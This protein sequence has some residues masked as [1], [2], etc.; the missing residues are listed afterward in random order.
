MVVWVVGTFWCL[1]VVGQDVDRLADLSRAAERLR[2]E[3][4]NYILQ[5]TLSM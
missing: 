3:E 1:P 4:E 2:V 5:R